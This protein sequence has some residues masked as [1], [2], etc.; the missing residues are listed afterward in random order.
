MS[1]LTLEALLQRLDIESQFLDNLTTL[2]EDS[3]FSF[4]WKPDGLDS[5]SRLPAFQFLL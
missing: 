5:L 1:R 4:S 2:Q 3:Q